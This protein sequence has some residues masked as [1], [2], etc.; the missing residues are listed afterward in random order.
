MIFN[1]SH[2]LYHD[3]SVLLLLTNTLTSPLMIP[4]SL[5]YWSVASPCNIWN[6]VSCGDALF[7]FKAGTLDLVRRDK[8][9]N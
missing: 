2:S 7:N 8:V 4:A 6:V 5:A 3:P 9:I 1:K